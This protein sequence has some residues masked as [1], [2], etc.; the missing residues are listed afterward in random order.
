MANA[1]MN[2]PC[3]DRDLMTKVETIGPVKLHKHI[4]K[5]MYVVN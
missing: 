5:E 2:G 1:V 3:P 4:H